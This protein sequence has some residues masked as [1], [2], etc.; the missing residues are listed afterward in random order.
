[1]ALAADGSDQ[2]RRHRPGLRTRLARIAASPGFQRW[3]AG[4]PFARRIARKEGEALFDLVQGFV[5]SQVLFA[6]VELRL[7]HRLVD[8]PLTVGQLAQ[9]TGITPDRMARLA[10]AAAAL[11][12]FRRSG[13]GYGIT[14]KGAALLGVPGL[15]QMIRHHDVLY[16]DLSDPVAF[17][18][19]EVQTELADF[20]PYVFGA[21]GASDPQVTATYSDLMAQSQGLVAQ[22]TLRAVSLKDVSHLVD[23]GGGSGAFAEAAALS[24]PDLRVTLFDLPPVMEAAGR[25]LETSPARGRIALHPGSFRDDPLPEGADAMALIRVLYDHQDD[26][27]RTLFRRVRDALPPGG[28]LVVSEPMSGGSRPEPAGDVY[29]AFYCMA[30]RTGTVRSQ[31]RIAALLVEAGFEQIDCPRSARPFVTSVVTARRGPE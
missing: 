23:I 1:M 19:G 6:V 12:L 22:D 21:G 20:W 27:V 26:T 2:A 14:R 18:R 13:E 9:G 10:Q 4:F 5:A 28:R 24:A 31:A 8:G 7:L 25:R 3:A 16:R 15:E 17:L 11:G 29:F 30:M